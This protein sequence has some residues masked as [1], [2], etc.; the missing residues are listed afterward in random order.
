MYSEISARAARITVM[1][2]Q[3]ANGISTNVFTLIRHRDHRSLGPWY[4]ENP[5][6]HCDTAP[7]GNVGDIR[8]LSLYRYDGTLAKCREIVKRILQEDKLDIGGNEIQFKLEPQPRHHWAYQEHTSSGIKSLNSPFSNCSAEICEYWCF[9]ADAR[10][11]WIATVEADAEAAEKIAAALHFPISQRT[12][13][14]GNLMIAK[15]HAAIESEIT[16]L[17]GNR[18]VLKV[19]SRDWT[20]PPQGEYSATIWAEHSGDRVFRRSLEVNRSEAVLNHESDVDLV[21]YEIYRNNDGECIDRYEAHLI[22]EIGFSMT[23]IGQPINIRVGGKGYSFERQINT[24]SFGSTSS[25]TDKNTEGL[26]QAIRQKHLEYNAY[27]TDRAARREGNLHR[28]NPEEVGEAIE[29]IAQLVRP[30]AGWNG[31]VYFA[32]PHF[33]GETET[34]VK[35]L[36]AILSE[37]YGQPLNI[38]C[39]LWDDQRKLGYLKSLV[40]QAELRSFTRTRDGRILPAFHDRYLITPDGETLITNSVNGWDKDGV[41]FHS[42]PYGAYR[43]ETEGLWYSGIGKKVD[44]WEGEA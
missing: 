37:T 24:N 38:L 12:D 19:A 29:H 25:I 3:D 22:K 4:Q 1:A 17:Q 27:E 21:G 6:W 39:G 18:L 42:S 15:A 8:S 13:R 32:D 20:E 35:M 34:E 5:T 11:K 31:P 26:D 36:T 2:M 23:V 40:A 33:K 41:T 7:V 30:K 28:F 14:V 10:E 9:D 44:L 16:A 43:A